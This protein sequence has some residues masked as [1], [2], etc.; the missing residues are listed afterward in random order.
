MVARGAHLLAVALLLA[1][2]SGLLP[3]HALWHDH[4][5]AHGDAHATGGCGHGHHSAPA[6]AN[7]PEEGSHHPHDCSI[8]K[9]ASQTLVVFSLTIL[10]AHELARGDA[11]A[12]PPAAA[13]SPW[14]TPQQSRAPPAA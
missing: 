11:P 8:C 6:P 10:P 2:F 5:H 3:A 1:W 4:G 9:L 14:R 12:E 7:E 13:V